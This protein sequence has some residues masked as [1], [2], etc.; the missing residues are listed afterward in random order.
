MNL[1]AGAPQGG[2]VQQSLTPQLGEL[3]PKLP[4]L[5]PQ[6]AV[7]GG[8]FSSLLL[9]SLDIG[10]LLGSTLGRR[11][12][13]LFSVLLT[14]VAESVSVVGRTVG[15]V[16]LRLFRLCV[17]LIC[18]IP[19]SLGTG[20]G[21]SQRSSLPS[22]RCMPYRLSGPRRVAF[23]VSVIVVVIVIR[24]RDLAIMLVYTVVT[25][26]DDTGWRRGRVYGELAISGRP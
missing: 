10:L 26:G 18:G 5:H 21:R 14:S 19:G 16:I 12:P 20:V 9:Q 1:S 15:L 2:V 25:T 24:R 4:C 11:Q 13:V 17:S 23:G 3:V 22:R 8:R 7:L 6:L